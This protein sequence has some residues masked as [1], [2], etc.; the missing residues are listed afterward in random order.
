MVRTRSTSRERSA[1][2]SA[3]SSLHCLFPPDAQMRL[4]KNE[5]MMVR[6]GLQFHW[7]NEGDASFDEYL[8]RMGC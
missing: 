8:A 7:V 5:G 1:S 2:D 4:F 3:A 6:H